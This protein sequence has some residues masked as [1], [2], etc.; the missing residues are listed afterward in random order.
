MFDIDG[1]LFWGQV[2][3]SKELEELDFLMAGIQFDADVN[4][5]HVAYFTMYS[6]YDLLT[7]KYF[8]LHNMTQIYGVNLTM[9]EFGDWDKV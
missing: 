8:T 5:T 9:L 7:P 1:Y 4:Q 3:T 6:Y 2:I